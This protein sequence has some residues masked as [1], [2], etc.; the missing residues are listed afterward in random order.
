VVGG[1][2]G[3]NVPDTGA[4]RVRAV[5]QIGFEVKVE[6]DMSLNDETSHGTEE[7]HWIVFNGEGQRSYQTTRLVI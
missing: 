1:M 4:A 5:T 6:E 3:Y 7:F 2:A